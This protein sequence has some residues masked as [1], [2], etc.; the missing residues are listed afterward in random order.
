[1][2]GINDLRCE[3]TYSICLTHQ[4]VHMPVILSIAHC[5]TVNLFIWNINR[6]YKLANF[7]VESWMFVVRDVNHLALVSKPEQ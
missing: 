7:T 3:I 5:A 2:C 6:L 4:V 1:M